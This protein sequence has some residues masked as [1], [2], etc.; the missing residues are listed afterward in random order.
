MGRGALP[1]QRTQ[2]REARTVLVFFEE[3]FQLLTGGVVSVAGQSGRSAALRRPE[4]IFLFQRGVHAPRH[5]RL[6]DLR[7]QQ[8]NHGGQIGRL[9]AVEQHVAVGIRD[10]SEA[11]N[12]MDEIREVTERQFLPPRCQ[13]AHAGE[14][15]VPIIKLLIAP[16]RTGNREWM[17]QAHKTVTILSLRPNGSIPTG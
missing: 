12:Q 5:A 13:Q 3:V 9:R 6:L 11:L 2:V 14:I 15:G 7:A 1:F 10:I 17:W 8:G 4:V 16:F